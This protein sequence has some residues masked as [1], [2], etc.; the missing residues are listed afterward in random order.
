MFWES[1]WGGLCAFVH[2]QTWVAIVE[3]LAIF[4][5]PTA[6][7][8]MRINTDGTK[9]GCLMMLVGPL[10]QCLATIVFLWTLAPILLN[11]RDEAA[12]V[13]PWQVLMGDPMF[14]MKVIAIMV[15]AA[16]VV[17]FLPVLGSMPTVLT[18]AL[19]IIALIFLVHALD[20]MSEHGPVRLLPSLWFILGLI[21]V[22]GVLAWL[23]MIV[24]ALIATGV[25]RWQEGLGQL[26]ALPVASLLGFIP[27][28]I[29]AAWLGLQ[30]KQ[31]YM[32]YS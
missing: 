7:V 12:W 26:L 30:L 32:G 17:G 20:S 10:L 19:G 15:V 1:V 31:A 6:L 16:I 2:W 24:T 9:A 3:Y 21:V 5:V 13:F 14:V 11:H 25:D 27:V 23:G 18:L 28:F 8:S 22:G 4:L 29:Y